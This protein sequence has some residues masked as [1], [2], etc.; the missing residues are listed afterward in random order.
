MDKEKFCVSIQQADNASLRIG[1]AN[2]ILQL[3]QKQRYSNNENSVKRW[4]WELCQNA[5]DVCNSTGKVKISIAYDEEQNK[6]CFRH[7]G[8]AFSMTNILSLINQASSKDRN[9]GSE[10]KSG[11]FGTGF[12]TT[13]LLSETVK[14]YGILESESTYS[15]FNI[16]LD[17]RGKEKN[18][19]ITAMENSI[20]D[21]QECVTIDV[22]EFSEDEYN[23]TF[24]YELDEYGVQ[25]AKDGLENL[26]V[27]APFVLTLLPE[28]EE[29]TIESTGET[30]R[31]NQNIRC[32]LNKASVSEIILEVKGNVKRIYVLNVTEDN[33]SIL[34]ALERTDSGMKIL[35]YSKQQSK[36]FCDF[37]LI[38]TEDFPFPVLINSQDFNPTEPRDGVFLTCGN[39]SR[40]DNEIV[41]NHAIIE[42]ACNLYKELLEYASEKK[43]D[44]IYNITRISSFEKKEWYDEEW[45]KGIIEK[46]KNIILHVPMVCT[47][48]GLMVELLDDWDD[49]QVYIVNGNNNDTRENIWHLL[50]YIMP[51]RIPQKS[52]IHEWYNS[53][54]SGCNRYGFGKLSKLLQSYENIETFKLYLTG[55]EWATWLTAYYEFT[56]KNDERK[57]LL[58]SEK[59]KILPNQNGE[60]CSIGQLY[61]DTGVLDEYK[62]ILKELG[63][64]S[65]A[66]LLDLK[67]DN[68]SW[69]QCKEYT[70]ED[71]LKLIEE[72]LQQTDQET[73][74]CVL[75][76]IVFMYENAYEQLPVQRKICEYASYILGLKYNM[77]SVNSTSKELL[78]HSMKRTV[79]CVANK[80]SEC[81]TVDGLAEYLKVPVENAISFLAGFIEFVVKNGY[82]NLLTKVKKPILPNQNGNF[83]TKENIFLDNE[84]DDV[85]KDIAC[86]AGYDIRAELLMNEVFLELPDN[87]QKSNIDMATCIT[88]FVDDNRTTKDADIRSAFNR[89]LIWINE[90][91]DEAARIFPSLY[92]N[93]HYLYDDEEIVKNIKRAE[94]LTN[95]MCKYN[96]ASA[97]KLEEIIQNSEEILCGGDFQE[98]ESI[99]E[100]VLLQYGIDSDEALD[101]AFANTE[102]S[103]KFKRESKHNVEAY[104][105]V[106][107]IL[108]R[109][110]NNIISYLGTQQ[111]YDVSEFQ[112]IADTIFVVKKNGKQIYVL[113]R[114]SDGGEVR[115][116]YRTEMDILDYSMDW[117]LWVEDGKS[118]PQ[119]ITFG[120]IIKLTG[121][122][123]IPLKG[124]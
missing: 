75:L 32:G 83:I 2:R 39:K 110:K 90:N 117:E 43:W 85:L 67:L 74:E 122:N 7:N 52:E 58:L 98:K 44:G 95:I 92:K 53:L 116:Y 118:V 69:F 105:Y 15:R 120:K 10:R 71:I 21:L 72:K 55:I 68:R 4:I 46:C 50:S 82:E 6:V 121:L 56:D 35:P 19:I 17:R 102:F 34:T 77:I 104:V 11:K 109:S 115:I 31:Y 62:L 51:D 57:K 36:L 40:I 108:N 111:E 41:T 59:I 29:I 86:L 60:F 76:K 63:V 103:S 100:E 18:E 64:D 9:D 48:N 14:I 8:K 96:I 61:F 99:T 88:R 81:S 45:L 26:R 107:R 30:F 79:T 112:E 123:R 24:E 113:A 25:V 49:E 16:F 70:N 38:G 93:K 5:K 22:S 13:H 73:E 97:D 101:E 78:Q 106:K 87:R 54:W 84:M 114:P 65:K 119:K 37:P 27:S 12:I 3:L 47:E 42:K 124:M 66:W 94:L 23:T 89:L 20:A 91:S 1:A 28:I 33:V 80:I